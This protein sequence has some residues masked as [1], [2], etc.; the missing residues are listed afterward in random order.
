MFEVTV[1]LRVFVVDD[2]PDAAYT[3]AQLLELL[4]HSVHAYANGRDAAEAARE[5]QPD[6]AVLDL[7]MP[8]IDGF[9][10]AALFHES[11]PGT[12]LIAWSGYSAPAD[13][14]RTRASGFYAHLPK[15]APLEDL[16]SAIEPPM[17]PGAA[18][19]GEPRH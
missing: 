15:T 19:A 13:R 2:N 3:L 18:N 7:G 9:A 17:P 4:G 6:V 12:R 1:P 10:T 16:T 14:A 5:L 8:E 11:S